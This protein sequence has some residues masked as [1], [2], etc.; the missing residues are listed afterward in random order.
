MLKPLK[1]VNFFR[2]KRIFSIGTHGIT[3]YN[4]NSLEVTNRYSYNQIIS[5]QVDPQNAGG[6]VLSVRDKNKLD[7]FKFSSDFRS[8]LLTDA[9]KFRHQF[10]ERGQEDI[11]V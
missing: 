4:P 3:T 9:L 2:Y 7:K 10:A 5:I 1:L 6:F 8:N 11:Y